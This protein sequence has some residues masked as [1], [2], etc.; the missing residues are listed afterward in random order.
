MTSPLANIYAR[1]PVAF[2]HGQGVWLWDANG[3][4]YLDALAGIGVSCLGHAHPKLVAAISEQAARVIH[5]SNIYEIPLQEALA[6]RLTALSGMR[7]VAFCNSGSEANEAA[8]KLA[9]YYAYQRGNR[10]AHIITMDSS[11][12]GRTLATLA[13][14]G[15]EKAR[16]GFEP[17][18][19]GFIQV[20]YNDLAAVRAAGDAEPST[21]AVLLEVLQGE[22][23]IRPSDITYL[24]ALRQL[25]TERGWLLMIDEVQ[26]GIGRTGKWFAHQWADIKPDVMT[27]AKGLAGGVPIGAMLAA[28]PAAGVF[29]PGSHGTT[30][31]GGPLV[32]AAGLAVLNTLETDKLLDNAHTVGSY[33]QNALASALAGTAGVTE[34][35]GRGLMLGIELARPCGVLALRAME[36]GLLINVTRDR[37]VRLLPPL[38]LNKQEADQIVATLVPLIQHF[39]AEH[40]SSLSRPGHEPGRAQ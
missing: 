24:Q 25:C 35:R 34:V 18:P 21:T 30:F 33:L 1:L 6:A 3:R 20:P 39:L 31:G 23:G 10:H 12:H 32:C 9:R 27:L 22:G 5:T 4:K 7:E 16:K 28:G 14:T 36:A 2:S 13:A 37:V 8:I 11:W 15:S 17:L 29:T 19:T 38:I 40:S 26:S